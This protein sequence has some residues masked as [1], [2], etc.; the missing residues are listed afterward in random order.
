[1]SH[2]A[3][4]KVFTTLR[5]EFPELPNNLSSHIL[6]HTW[7]DNYSVQMDKNRVNATDEIRTRSYLMGWSQTSG[8]AVRYTQRSTRS[9]AAEHSRAMQKKVVGKR[10]SNGNS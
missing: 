1:M 10:K 4:E 9:R 8:T 6:R 2:E 5:K 3:V 7:N